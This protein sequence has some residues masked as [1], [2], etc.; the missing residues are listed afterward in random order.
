MKKFLKVLLG[1]AAAGAF[2]GGAFYAIKK[3]AKKDA[4]AE[5]VTEEVT[6]EAVEEVDEPREE[7]VYTT[8]PSTQQ[9]AADP[10]E[11]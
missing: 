9:E 11:E 3:A 4:E 10:A 2:V 8:I 5:Y 7:R 6:T 1:A